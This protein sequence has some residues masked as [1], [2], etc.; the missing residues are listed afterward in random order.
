M[1][2]CILSIDQGTSST[3][4]IVFDDKGKALYK[5][6]EPLKTN[7]LPGN[8]VEQDPEEIYQNVLSA[9]EKCA[10]G[11]T[12][13]GGDVGNIRACGISNQ[14]ETFIL[15]DKNGKPLSN[16][17]VWLCKRSV[18][19]CER[20][21]NEGWEETIKNKTGLIIDPYFSGTKVLCLYEKD[22]EVRSAVDSGE[23]FFGTVDAWLLCR[24]TKGEQY[25]TDYTNASRTMFFN[26]REMN[27][28]HE[29]LEMFGL[30]KLNLPETRPSS[31]HY[32][33]TD[34][35]G[36]LNAPIDICSMIGDSHAAAF[37]EGLYSPGV[38]KATLGTGCSVMMNIGPEIKWSGHGM[39]PTICWSAPGRTDYAMEG[40]IVTCGAAIEWL[41][42]ELGLFGS[43]EEIEKMNASVN[44]NNGVYLVPAFSGLGAPHW[45]MNRRA[46][47][48][49]L[50]FDCNKNHVVRA[51]LESIPYQIK[52]V[53]GAME[54]DSGIRLKELQVDG[55]ITSNRF[56]LQFLAD[57]LERPVVNIGIADVSALGAAYLAG[58]QCGVFKDLQQ[59]ASFGK[60]KATIHPGEGATKVKEYY[61]G[62]L[63]AIGIGLS[64]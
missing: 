19:V 10:R 62:W 11:F 52:D 16:A 43:N 60:G 32:G 24:L 39:V 35:E 41:K 63:K 38:A 13:S 53:I 46:S 37:G 1:T 29:L 40:I 20:L 49:G 61:Q 47:I 36:R 27:W 45:D 42:N 18:E 58:L 59:I 22:K 25:M 56:V 17:V 48:V 44:D 2:N 55:G 64:R 7:Y 51:A 15:W 28:D 23:A 33:S 12:D 14:R 26:I 54:E 34:F 50:S 8:L 6:S 5:A 30:S 3:K 4:A 21:K 57:L 31:F 9:V